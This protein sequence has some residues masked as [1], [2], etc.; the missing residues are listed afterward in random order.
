MRFNFV[1]GRM[2]MNIFGWTASIARVAG[3]K[4]G[5]DIKSA[6]HER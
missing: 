1:M 4:L 3:R 5:G 2:E 6:L